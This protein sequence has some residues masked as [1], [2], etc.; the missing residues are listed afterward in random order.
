MVGS[1]WLISRVLKKST[2]IHCASVLIVFVEQRIFRSLYWSFSLLST[3]ALFLHVLHSC[4]HLSNLSPNPDD[5]M[6]LVFLELLYFPYILYENSNPSHQTLWPGR[7]QCIPN[8]PPKF[9]LVCSPIYPTNVVRRKKKSFNA[10][11]LLT[12]C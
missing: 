1:L 12:T 4:V 2:L 3:G 7:L 9:F 8:I 6:F 11:F 10:K 5:Y